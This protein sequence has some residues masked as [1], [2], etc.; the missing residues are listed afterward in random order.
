MQH[1]DG[2]VRNLLLLAS[3]KRQWKDIAKDSKIPRGSLSSFM[4]GKKALSEEN[5]EKA[6]DW[7]KS[8]GRWEDESVAPTPKIIKSALTILADDLQALVDTLRSDEFSEEY[9]YS[10][11]GSWANMVSITMRKAE[12]H[13]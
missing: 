10:R 2:H 5:L 4:S 8:I 1:D 9:K 11:F 3:Y 12:R 13:D 6:V 7:L